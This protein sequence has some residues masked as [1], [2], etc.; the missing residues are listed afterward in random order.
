M[1]QYNI[2]KYSHFYVIGISYKKADANIRGA[3]SLDSQH[4]EALLADAQCEGMDAL[5]V[6]STCNRTELYGF[7]QHPFQ[8]IQKLCMHSKASID[9][10]QKVGYVY[11]NK[12]AFDHIF[13]VGTGLDSQILGD[14][15]IIS[16]F[17]KSFALSKKYNLIN[18]FMER[19]QNAVIQAS[20][21]VKT[22]TELSS[23]ATSVSFAAVQYL[24][25]NVKN[26]SQKNILLFGVG[27]IGRNTCENLVKHIDNKHITL[28]NRTKDKAD[29]IAG[30]FNLI[31]KN[32][33]DLSDE[34]K[35]SD[36]LI[37][38]T[39]A[40]NPTIDKQI[41]P[42]GK[43]MVILDLSI[44]K[45]VNDN[46][47]EHQGITLIHM[48]YLSQITDDTLEQRKLYI[49]QAQQ[50]IKEVKKEFFEWVESRKFVPTIKALKTKLEIMKNAEIDF[51]RKKIIDFN[52]EQAEIL[53]NRIIQK[54]T[55]QFMNYLKESASVEESLVFVQQIFQL[56]QMEMSVDK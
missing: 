49:P 20:K 46:V 34:I 5:M 37:V 19:L 52:E 47:I 28:I 36:I 33:Q 7:A 3:F 56:N 18:A 41:I 43:Q 40:E 6:I 48:D 15:E 42:Q 26:I 31:V 17:K 32:Y 16:Q 53:S 2:S 13:N 11:K 38:A 27:K 12:D 23:G 55:T 8:L 22:E 25:K 39:G 9:D 51:Q 54:I 29:E 45:N 10:F 24:L 35:Q 21:R 14:F 4:Q 44:P 30:K 1:Q 50:I